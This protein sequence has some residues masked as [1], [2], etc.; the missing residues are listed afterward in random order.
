MAGLLKYFTSVKRY[1]SKDTDD[2]EKY[3]PDPNSEL[4][5]VV[6]SSIEAT[7]TVVREAPAGETSTWPIPFT[8]SSAEVCHWEKS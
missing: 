5:K 8:Y 7:N 6:P 4:S 1:R 2:E 3:L